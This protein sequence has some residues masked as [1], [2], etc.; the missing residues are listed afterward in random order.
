MGWTL[1]TLVCH[2]GSE[3]ALWMAC[4]EILRSFFCLGW[5]KWSI[6]RRL[7]QEDSHF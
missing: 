1:W 2:L 3:Q 5:G 6:C 4:L 7:G